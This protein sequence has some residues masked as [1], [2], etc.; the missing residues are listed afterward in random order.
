MAQDNLEYTLKLNKG[1]FDSSMKSAEEATKKLDDGFSKLKETMLT[2]VGITAGVE[3]FKSA[4]EKFVEADKIATQLKFTLSMRG[5]L[6]GSFAELKE[7]SEELAGNSMFSHTEIEKAEIALLNYG[8]SVKNVKNHMQTL[9]DIGGIKDEGIEEIAMKVAQATKVGRF[10]ALAEYGIDVK[11]LTEEFKNGAT[12]G[13]LFNETMNLL[14]KKFEGA[15]AEL[16]GTYAGKIHILKMEYEHLQETIGGKLIP[17]I[18]ELI[19][20][21]KENKTTLE[22]LAIGIVAVVGALKTYSMFAEI[23]AAINP[24]TAAIAAAALLLAAFTKIYLEQKKIKEQ[25]L[26]AG[27]GQAVNQVNGY[28]DSQIEKLKK[29]GKLSDE[30]TQ[31]MAYLE[32][33]GFAQKREREAESALN[34]AEK[35]VQNMSKF[36]KTRYA[37]QNATGYGT[38]NVNP[39]AVK[40]LQNAQQDYQ[41][42]Q[43]GLK[44]A[45]AHKYIK[46]QN[47]KDAEAPPTKEEH[48]NEHIVINI[49]KMVEKLE[50]HPATIAASAAQ[51]RDQVGALFQQVITGSQLI[52]AQ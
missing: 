10:R 12:Q 1:N 39:Q 18:L 36:D 40:D 24:F 3:F 22:S 50:I 15:G 19:K 33:L 21:V 7:Q 25:N 16:M 44:A 52:K 31:K 4:I 28:Y 37:L 30:N 49:Q 32:T 47:G 23:S 9:A 35:A 29:I 46:A 5:G 6:A 13:Y 14:N 27:E 41:S 2:I 38:S 48:H 11:H 17:K 51:I 45:N 26:A 42:A 8:V 43:A 34:D 20:W